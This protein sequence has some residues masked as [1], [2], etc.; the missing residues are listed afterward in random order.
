MVID[1]DDQVKALARKK[2]K[3]VNLA[4]MVDTDIE[5]IPGKE[6]TPE[7]ELGQF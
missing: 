4:G 2:P 6:E 7:E 5:E 3:K 1:S